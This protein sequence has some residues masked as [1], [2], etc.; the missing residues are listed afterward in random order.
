MRGS[1]FSAV[2]IASPITDPGLWEKLESEQ[3]SHD[4]LKK[5]EEEADR[6]LLDLAMGRVEK[7]VKP[8]TWKA[9][10]LTTF[11]GMTAAQAARQ[12]RLKES[13][14]FVARHRIQ[15]ML[16]EEVERIDAAAD[17]E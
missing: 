7:R 10:R 2:E 14:V 15:H 4:F 1:I 16:V 9:F 3:I 13:S 5:L 17:Q 11:H 12:L 8:H 6:E